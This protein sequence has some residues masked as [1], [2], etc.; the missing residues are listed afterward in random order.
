MKKCNESNTCDWVPYKGCKKKPNENSQVV[1]S[2]SCTESKEHSYEPKSIIHH[3][4]V[5]D[6]VHDSDIKIPGDIKIPER[7]YQ[8]HVE[9]KCEDDVYAVSDGVIISVKGDNKYLFLK[10]TFESFNNEFRKDTKNGNRMPGKMYQGVRIISDYYQHK[11]I[12]DKTGDY[13]DVIVVDYHHQMVEQY[14]NYINGGSKQFVRLMINVDPFLVQSFDY[15]YL[16]QIKYNKNHNDSN[17]HIYKKSY[18]PLNVLHPNHKQQIQ[19][20]NVRPDKDYK[21]ETEMSN[22]NS[23]NNYVY[24]NMLTKYTGKISIKELNSHKHCIKQHYQ[25]EKTYEYSDIVLNAIDTSFKELFKNKNV[26]ALFHIPLT[27]NVISFM[28]NQNIE[29]IQGIWCNMWKLYL[30]Y[31][32]QIHIDYNETYNI[33][34]RYFMDIFS[35]IIKHRVFNTYLSYKLDTKDNHT[36]TTQI[37]HFKENGV[38]DMLCEQIF[39]LFLNGKIIQMVSDDNIVEEYKHLYRDYESLNS[40][41]PV[42]VLISLLSFRK[43]VEFNLDGY[44]FNSIF[45]SVKFKL[46][47]HFGLSSK[48][49]NSLKTFNNDLQNP[50]RYFRFIKNKVNIDNARSFVIHGDNTVTLPYLP[51]VYI[52]R[53]MSLQ[54]AYHNVRNDGIISFVG[55]DELLTSTLRILGTYQLLMKTSTLM[56]LHHSMDKEIYINSKRALFIENVR[57][58]ISNDKSQ[59]LD[60]KLDEKNGTTHPFIQKWVSYILSLFESRYNILSKYYDENDMLKSIQIMR[61]LFNYDDDNNIEFIQDIIYSLVIRKTFDVESVLEIDDMMVSLRDDMD[62]YS[63]FIELSPFDEKIYNSLKDKRNLTLS[64]TYRLSE[65]S[66]RYQLTRDMNNFRNELKKLEEHGVQNQIQYTRYLRLTKRINEYEESVGTYSSLKTKLEEISN[67]VDKCT[68]I[69]QEV[70]YFISKHIDPQKSLYE[71]IAHLINIF[72]INDENLQTKDKFTSNVNYLNSSNILDDIKDGSLRKNLIVDLISGEYKSLDGIRDECISDSSSC[73][74]GSFISTYI[75]T[76]QP[77]MRFSNIMYNLNSR[78]G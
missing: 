69:S 46:Y 68:I 19:I 40:M 21:D 8:N 57:N 59:L 62:K 54:E 41:S 22:W 39:E 16:K 70:S 37:K 28:K 26:R 3:T 11:T 52:K 53:G 55:D 13:V 49:R 7:E 65:L 63:L 10:D 77:N 72:Y 24:S 23:V 78:S 44:Y 38:Y 4:D 56:I 64:E 27:H 20:P 31:R 12:T 71:T 15:E 18:H 61:T 67:K 74:V 51:R 33:S 2:D 5:K 42:D 29:I 66:R 30:Y 34:I 25:V 35:N 32:Q 60:I 9:L 76:K 47:G 50:D 14:L 43:G 75:E 1:S 36:I 17:I 6:H 48:M 45:E 58:L 73:P